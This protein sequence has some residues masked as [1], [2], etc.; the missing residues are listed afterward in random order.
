[1]KYLFFIF[2]PMGLGSY[3]CKRV[4]PKAFVRHTCY[5]DKLGR[6]L[7]T[8]KPGFSKKPKTK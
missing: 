2:P 4:T 1:M 7:L 6:L 3:S 8:I 5:K